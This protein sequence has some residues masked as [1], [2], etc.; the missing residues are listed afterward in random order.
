M[1][2]EKPSQDPNLDISPDALPRQEVVE[3]L[4]ADAVEATWGAP[5]LQP[6]P[7]AERID[8]ADPATVAEAQ[9][10]LDGGLFDGKRIGE[11]ISPAP[12]PIQETPQEAQSLW[13]NPDVTGPENK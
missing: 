13:M 11:P 5:E 12:K 6:I 7:N 8:L 4:G 10:I 1:T 2:P 3:H 9:R